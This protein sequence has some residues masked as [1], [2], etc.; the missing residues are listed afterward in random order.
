M[1][2]ANPLGYLDRAA[3]SLAQSRLIPAPARA[4]IA[5][6]ADFALRW[7]RGDQSG[8]QQLSR[9]GGPSQTDRGAGG[10][11]EEIR[12][13][14]GR[15]AHHFR[16]HEHPHGAGGTD[17][18]FQ[19]HRSLR[20][21]SVGFRGER[22]NGFRDSGAGGSHHFRRAESRQHHRRLPVIESQDSRVPAQGHGASG[23]NPQGSGR[24][25]A[26]TNC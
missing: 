16:D 8:K 23:G 19:A 11:G 25:R 1:T 3:R 10:R 6:R 9:A 7:P 18:R 17:R 24:R 14:I 15:G 12:R 4:R 21:V 5:V 22:R 20:G 13:G 2:T 26:A